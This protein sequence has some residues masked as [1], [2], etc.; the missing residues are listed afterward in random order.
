VYDNIR[1]SFQSVSAYICVNIFDHF[2]YDVCTS[3]L[4]LLHQHRQFQEEAMQDRFY[5]D[6]L[7]AQNCLGAQKC[8]GISSS[9]Q[10][11]CT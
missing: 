9:M 4:I 7:G 10:A 3:L 8:S 2:I 6:W 5:Y 11:Y 1:S